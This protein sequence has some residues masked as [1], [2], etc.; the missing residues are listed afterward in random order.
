MAR[1]QCL[2]CDASGWARYALVPHTGRRH[3]LRAHLSA[4]GLPLR[5][6]PYYPQVSRGAQDADDWQHPLQLL[7]RQLGFVDPITG[8]TRLFESRLQ[9]DWPPAAL[10]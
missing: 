6:D 7:A 10:A 4:L 1:W 3:Q 9:L 5:H 2:A 8:E